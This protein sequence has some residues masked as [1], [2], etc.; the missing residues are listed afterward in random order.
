M[1][2][3]TE[4]SAREKP[5]PFMPVQTRDA[6]GM[7]LSAGWAKAFPAECFVPSTKGKGFQSHCSSPQP[8]FVVCGCG[9]QTRGEAVLSFFSPFDSS[10]RSS[11]VCCCL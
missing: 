7:Y 9:G 3:E 11:G 1:L 5:G 10:A 6:G 4:L 2:E 8:Q